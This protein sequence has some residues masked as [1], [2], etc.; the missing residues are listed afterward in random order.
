MYIKVNCKDISYHT[1][2]S[3]VK[4]AAEQLIYRLRGFT[5]E[6]DRR[7]KLLRYWRSQ[8]WGLVYAYTDEEA[9]AFF[10][11]GPYSICRNLFSNL[12]SVSCKSLI[13][14]DLLPERIIRIAQ[15]RSETAEEA[16][17][18]TL[19]GFLTSTETNAT[20]SVMREAFCRDME[21]FSEVFR[22]DHIALTTTTTTTT[23]TPSTT[24]TPPSVTTTPHSTNTSSTWNLVKPRVVQVKSNQAVQVFFHEDGRPVGCDQLQEWTQPLRWTDLS[25]TWPLCA[26]LYDSSSCMSASWSLSIPH[27]SMKRFLYWS[28]D[29]KYRSQHFTTISTALSILPSTPTSCIGMMRTW[30]R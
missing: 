30:S 21:A 14:S 29:F 23:T 9:H 7:R 13:D 16:L 11:E 15:N 1:V 6:G 10:D 19:T 18:D 4:E 8:N 20:S 24:T 27:D 2:S 12:N 26:V 28:S 22:A 25:K 17:L 3:E 5:T